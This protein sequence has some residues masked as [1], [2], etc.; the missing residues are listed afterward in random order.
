MQKGVQLEIGVGEDEGEVEA[1]GREAVTDDADL[2]GLRHDGCFGV[3]ISSHDGVPESVTA[4]NFACPSLDASML[5]PTSTPFPSSAS[6]AAEFAAVVLTNRAGSLDP[7]FRPEM[8][9]SLGKSFWGCN[10]RACDI[11]LIGNRG[12][13]IKS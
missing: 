2:D 10:L 11:R 1:L 9:S 5:Y 3:G 4:R 8:P 6:V 12:V 7:C 13:T